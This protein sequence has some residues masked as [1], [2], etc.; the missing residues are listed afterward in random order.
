MRG[1]TQE[2][3]AAKCQ[4]AGLD[5]SRSTLAKIEA[6]LRCATDHDVWVIAKILKVPLAELFSKQK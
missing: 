1:L 5:I 3:L 4:I 2:Q 6:G